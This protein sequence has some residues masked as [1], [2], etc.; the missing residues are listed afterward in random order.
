MEPINVSEYEPLAQ[1]RME[2]G[3]W[4]YFQGGSDD[5]V[6]LR[7]CRRAFEHIRLR[8]RMLV[9]TSKL[10][11]STT[12]LGTPVSMPVLVAPS[13]YHRLAHPEGECATAQ[14]VGM[15]RTLMIASTFS[16]RS[17]E[18][19]A[20]AASGPLWFQMYSYRGLDIP[21]QLVRRAEAAGYRAIVVTVDA[22]Q[23]G[24]R[25]RDIR[26]DFKLP[27]HVRPANVVFDEDES[28]IPA[29]TILPWDSLDWLRGITSL[30]LLL[31]G[32]LTAE[33]AVM[34]VER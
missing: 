27:A 19:I 13:A 31:K 8:P 3:A 32:V 12:V 15:A 24:K 33:D 17:I 5:E 34:A 22:P 2:P 23:L 25:E 11:L 14:G 6:T 18:E 29:P 10:D 4:D 16:T 7:E 26:N 21:A 30:P 28:Y 20:A 9:D 1:A